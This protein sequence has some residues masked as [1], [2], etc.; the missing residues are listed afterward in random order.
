LLITTPFD[1]RLKNIAI[2]TA[3]DTLFL[4]KMTQKYSP[5]VTFVLFLI[6]KDAYSTLHLPGYCFD[7]STALVNWSNKG[8]VKAL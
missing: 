4:L 6:S 8:E 3:L 1:L 2:C 7:N 5:S